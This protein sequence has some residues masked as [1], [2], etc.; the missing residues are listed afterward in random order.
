MCPAVERRVADADETVDL[1]E[2]TARRTRAGAYDRA[3][4]HLLPVR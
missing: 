3:A 2:R 1:Q 4:Y